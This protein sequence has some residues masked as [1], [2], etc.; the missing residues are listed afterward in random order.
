MQARPTPASAGE[1]GRK[2]S[3]EEAVVG[4]EGEPLVGKAPL[5]IS[6]FEVVVDV[7]RLG[8]TVGRAPPLPTPAYPAA[9]PAAPLQLRR[10]RI[11]AT[12]G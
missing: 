1:S 3:W 2:A 8:P 7:G 11:R 12:V 4:R 9:L 6:W 10:R 5:C